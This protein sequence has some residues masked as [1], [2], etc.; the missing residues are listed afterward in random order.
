VKV[1]NSDGT[2]SQFQQVYSSF[3]DKW[4]TTDSFGEVKF[5]LPEGRQKILG[6]FYPESQAL[7][8]SRGEFDLTVNVSSD[9]LIKLPLPEVLETSLRLEDPAGTPLNQ[10]PVF[11]QPTY[12][13]RG[14]SLEVASQPLAGLGRFGVSGPYFVFKSPDGARGEL[15]LGTRAGIRAGHSIRA[16]EGVATFAVFAITPLSM[17]TCVQTSLGYHLHFSP[18]S[19]G[20]TDLAMTSQEFLSGEH[21]FVIRGAPTFEVDPLP[22]AVTSNSYMANF[23]V[24]G[25]LSSPNSAY[26]EVNGGIT[27]GRPESGASNSLGLSVGSNE[28]KANGDFRLVVYVNKTQVP[29]GSVFFLKTDTNFQSVLLKVPSFLEVSQRTLATFSNNATILT[30][31]QRGQVKAA[32][33]ANPN[34]EK[35]ICTGIR[36]YSQPM[37]VNI[38]VR[39]RAKA[40]CEY[41]KELNPSLSTWYQNK[42]TQARS[43]AGKVLLTIKSPPKMVEYDE[44]Q[45]SPMDTFTP[46]RLPGSYDIKQFGVVESSS[47]PTYLTVYIYTRDHPT[48][49]Q[50]LG[51]NNQIGLLFDFDLNGV[52]DMTL[53]SMGDGYRAE[54]ELVDSQGVLI[55]SAVFETNPFYPWVPNSEPYVFF[56]VRKE[57][58]P[59]GDQIAI[60]SWSKFDDGTGDRLPETGSIIFQ[61]PWGPE[62]GR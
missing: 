48:H 13:G 27:V 10:I 59:A 16:E 23:V 51:S 28:I 47:A 30:S 20:N 6:R 52:P 29:P 40:A 4:V 49:S 19:I 60:A 21:R 57:C 31:Q 8:I 46:P 45:M 7:N 53:S 25:S 34:A 3:Y 1:T 18:A 39:K 17:E 22:K 36:Y 56:R 41:A 26:R 5:T 2:P 35:F 54:G 58:L 55:C 37:S 43:Y 12:C 15:G 61:S 24:T 38:M 14:P 33:E 42:P 11:L 44:W 62:G 50:Y 32:V 9:L